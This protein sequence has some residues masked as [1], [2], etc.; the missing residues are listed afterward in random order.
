[1]NTVF[2]SSGRMVIPLPF[3]KNDASKKERGII[4]I[5]KFLIP[6]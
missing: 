6:T 2:A 5:S 1:M 4:K 3:G